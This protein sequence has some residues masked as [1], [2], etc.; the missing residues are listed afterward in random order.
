LNVGDYKFLDFS[1]DGAIN[2][3]DQMPI[4]GNLYPPIT[5]SLGGGFS[6]RDFE[7]SLLFQGNAGK[8]VDFNQS[9]ENEFTKGT[10]R[11]HESALDYWTPTNQDANHSTL[12]YVG[13]GD[14]LLLKWGGGEADRGY[15][16]KVQDR[17]WRNADYLRIK[18][19][20]M[21]Y[22]INAPKLE[23]LAGI[24]N[25]MVY[26]S[27]N[28]VYTFTNLIEGDPERKD[29]QQGFYPQMMTLK[30]GLKLAF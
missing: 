30:L 1:A 18:E 15:G 25:F 5:Y 22:T 2:N 4:K 9:Y 7:F 12:H 3:L 23:K 11:I 10:W 20:Y 16:I 28:N 21:G 8:Y 29:F 17:F 19:I 14:A 24:S 6:F 27:A 13:A 26:A